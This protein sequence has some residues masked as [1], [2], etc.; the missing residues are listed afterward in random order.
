MAEQEGFEPTHVFTSISF[1]DCPLDRLGTAPYKV[2]R[3]RRRNT[4]P[5]GERLGNKNGKES[6][7]KTCLPSIIIAQKSENARTFLFIFSTD[8]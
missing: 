7:G 3:S 5:A 6:T 1:Q 8:A 4:G 2:V